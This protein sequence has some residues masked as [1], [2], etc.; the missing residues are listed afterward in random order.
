MEGQKWT[1]GNGGRKFIAR[2]RHEKRKGRER[3]FLIKK[4]THQFTTSSTAHIE[5]EFP[6]KSFGVDEIQKGQKRNAN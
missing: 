5:S 2:E 1:E 6:M 4:T 3:L